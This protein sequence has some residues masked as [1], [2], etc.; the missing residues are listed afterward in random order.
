VYL[1]VATNLGI[2]GLIVFTLFIAGQLRLLS[3]LTAQFGGQLASMA[4]LA[5][6]DSAPLNDAGLSHRRDLLL[7]QQ[8]AKAAQGFIIVRLALGM[9]GMDLYEIYWWFAVGLTIALYQIEQ[10]ARRRT[11]VLVASRSTG[12]GSR[13]GATTLPDRLRML[14][15][16][17]A[18]S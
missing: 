16:A 7:F 4:E 3:R 10:I 13:T 15:P 2:Q 6:P 18:L 1:E 11:D 12:S 5:G 14:R 9:F 17:G 8:T